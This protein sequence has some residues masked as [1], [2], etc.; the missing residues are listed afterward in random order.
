MSPAAAATTIT[1]L[2]RPFLPFCLTINT[3]PREGVNCAVH[4]NKSTRGPA[5]PAIG[6]ADDMR[7]E[8]PDAAAMPRHGVRQMSAGTQRR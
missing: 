6:A 8:T 4:F 5:A 3:L 1:S 7:Q 2:Y